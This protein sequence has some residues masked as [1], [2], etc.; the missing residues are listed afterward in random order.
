MKFERS[1]V[2]P[3]GREKLW[4]LVMDVVRVG[5][6]FPG[7]EQVTAQ[8]DQR[9]EGMMRVRVGPVTLNMAGTI[10]VLE[11]D[12]E[13]WHASMRLEGTDRRIGGSVR[14]SMQLD[15]TERSAAETELQVSSDVSFL[16]KLGE[17]GQPI[18]RRKADSV[19]KEFASNLSREAESL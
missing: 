10:L 1:L 13:R 8:D 18:I 6:C 4:D 16:G 7:V 15:L 17:L 19:I 5:K 9:Y 2:V 11:Q 3:V 14:G 12:R